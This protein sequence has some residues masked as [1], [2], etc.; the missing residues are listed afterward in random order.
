[1]IRIRTVTHLSLNLSEW[2]IIV[3][4]LSRKR[5]DIPFVC[6]FFSTALA[7]LLCRA[8]DLDVS[9][10]DW[11]A[12]SLLLSTISET[13]FSQSARTTWHA[14]R[15]RRRIA[16]SALGL[17]KYADQFAVQSLRMHGPFLF[18]GRFLETVDEEKLAPLSTGGQR[19]PAPS[20][21][22]RPSL[23]RIHPG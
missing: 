7:D 8:D 21:F 18:A 23:G 11:A 14:F 19:R 6:P 4:N 20:P 9:S 12:I 17:E 2:K 13:L 15:Q 16:L 10:E 5:P 1:M 3:G 22:K